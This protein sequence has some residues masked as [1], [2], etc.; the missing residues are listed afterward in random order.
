[1]Y[2]KPKQTP[3][4]NK[5]QHPTKEEST[6]FNIQHPHSPQPTDRRQDKRRG[7]GTQDA[8][9]FPPVFSLKIPHLSVPKE[10]LNLPRFSFHGIFPPKFAFQSSYGTWLVVVGLIARHNPKLLE[11]QLSNLRPKPLL[12]RL[13]H[14]K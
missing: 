14:Y 8:L 6:T 13:K 9:C 12:R 2:N 3:T 5:Q 1:V 10:F 4:N 7:E 11:F